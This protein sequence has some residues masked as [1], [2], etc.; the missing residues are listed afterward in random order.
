MN[1]IHLTHGSHVTPEK[2]MLLANLILIA[3]L[4][5][6]LFTERLLMGKEELSQA[7]FPR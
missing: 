6:R 5:N 2:A 7:S 3:D 4:K 1:P